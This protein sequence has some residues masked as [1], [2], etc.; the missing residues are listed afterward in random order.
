MGR[1]ARICEPDLTYHAYT[2]CG[3]KKDLMYS[4]KLKDLMFTVINMALEKYEYKFE[5]NHFEILSNHFH[6]I[7]TT[8]PEGPTISRIMQYINSLD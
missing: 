1:K 7:I 8:L 4:D 3:N 6:L 5:L 2:R